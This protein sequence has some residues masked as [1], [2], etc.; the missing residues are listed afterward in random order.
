MTTVLP[1]KLCTSF[2]T[3]DVLQVAPELLGKVIVRNLNNGLM[4]HF[5][6]TEVEAYRGEE[7]LACHASKGHTPR[8]DVMYLE[9]GHVYVYLIYGIYYMLNFVT[10]S[11]DNPQAVLIRGVDKVI[12]S[13]RVGRLL[14]I[15]KS[16]NRQ[17]LMTSDE[18]W[19]E[20]LGKTFP[21]TTHPRIGVDY[22]GEFWKNKPWRYCAI[23]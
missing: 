14:K 12:G 5:T 18:I 15:N 16:H 21:F 19:V 1:N 22:A 17:N 4:Q 10:S 8:T 11:V 9:G 6:I 13:G 3:R 23:Q 7:D 2:F 20:D